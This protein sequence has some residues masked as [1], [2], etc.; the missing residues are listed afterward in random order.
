MRTIEIGRDYRLAG[1]KTYEGWSSL[2]H[3]R[4]FSNRSE[5]KRIFTLCLFAVLTVMPLAVLSFSLGHYLVLD[6]Q[7]LGFVTVV[8]LMVPL[9]LVIALLLSSRL[10]SKHSTPIERLT[11]VLRT[12]SQERDYAIRIGKKGE[13]G[14]GGLIEEVNAILQQME[15]QEKKVKEYRLELDQRISKSTEILTQVNITQERLILELHE[16][17][18]AKSE[19]LA[20]MSH[21]IRTPLNHILGFSELV[22][23]PQFGELNDT[24]KEFLS[25]VVSSS[26]HLLSLIN[27]ILDLSK[28]EAGKMTLDLT[29][30]AP[31]GLLEKSLGIV[32]EKALKGGIRLSI[33]LDDL[34]E[35]FQGDERKLRQVLYNLLSNAVKFTG[36][37]GQVTLAA[38]RV[39][40][41][42]QEGHRW[43]YP[44]ELEMVTENG[45]DPDPSTGEVRECLEITV[46]DTGI[47]LKEE[48][49]QRIFQPF[50]QVRGSI[51]GQVQGTGL[52][53]TLTKRMV[54]MHGGKIWV[55]SAGK[56]RGSAFG[57]II[58]I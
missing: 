41:R 20:N 28:I 52:G 48:D 30:V 35:T 10:Q 39:H 25:D 19:F 42:I 7:V 12:V 53:L 21:E 26:R 34:P 17:N 43:A 36:N 55:K 31:K 18:R 8:G 37:G 14:I 23:D 58:P 27:E 1:S 29:T 33:C 46:S 4:L 44:E 6:N 56:D 49:Q 45:G 13:D 50:E 40:C 47:G 15:V 2:I 38:R 51:A 3:M 22:L 9:T 16:A 57:F 11:D 32:R 54:E 5:K 24:Q